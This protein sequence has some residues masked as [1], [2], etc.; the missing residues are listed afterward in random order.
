MGHE[1]T[2]LPSSASLSLAEVIS[3]SSSPPDLVILEVWG[4]SLPLPQDLTDC[5]CPL[6]SRML[7]SIAKKALPHSKR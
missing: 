4:G 5:P 1:V 3:S 6:A 2:T 7:S